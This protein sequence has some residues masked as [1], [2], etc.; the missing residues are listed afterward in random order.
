MRILLSEIALDRHG[1]RITAAVPQAVL[2]PVPPD[3]P[4][5]E[6][7]QAAKSLGHHSAATVRRALVARLPDTLGTAARPGLRVA[8]RDLDEPVRIAAFAGLRRI[9][10]IDGGVV[11]LARGLLVGGAPGSNELRVAAAAA[12][13]DVMLEYR[14]EAVDVLREAIRQRSRSLIGIL[15]L[16]DESAPDDPSVLEAIGRALLAIGGDDGRREV[17]RRAA[18]SRADVRERLEALLR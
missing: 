2:H 15:R 1:L 13:G 7:A 5:P 12:L 17:E 16:A 14:I 10:A 6:L 4:L 11:S 3:G 18:A 8:A 9:R